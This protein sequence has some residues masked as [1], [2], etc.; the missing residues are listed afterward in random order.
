MLVWVSVC[1]LQLVCQCNNLGVLGEKGGGTVTNINNVVS[2]H[3]HKATNCFLDIDD[4]LH[5]PICLFALRLDIVSAC[6][7][8][9]L[10]LF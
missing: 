9:F 2:E 5:L 6:L 7:S 10:C 1:V 8:F 4:A 3:V